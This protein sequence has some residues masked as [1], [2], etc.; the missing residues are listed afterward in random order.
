MTTIIDE[1][2]CDSDFVEREKL[3]MHRRIRRVNG[4]H[5][6]ERL[7]ERINYVGFAP[8]VGYVSGEYYGRTL[9]HSG[10]YI[11]FDKNSNSQADIKK[12]TNR[13]MRKH[14]EIPNKKCNYYRRLLGVWSYIY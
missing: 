6:N 1:I 5:K 3:K 7:Y 10:Y 8:H 9:L 2:I 4:I 13:R 14:K 12:K 11:K